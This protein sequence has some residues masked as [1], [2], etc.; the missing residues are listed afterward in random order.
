MIE[1]LVPAVNNKLTSLDVVKAELRIVTTEHDLMLN[2]MIDQASAI[3]TSFCGRP[4]AVETYQET[5]VGEDSVHLILGH[6]PI[7]SVTSVAPVIDFEVWKEAGM[8]YRVNGW[9]Q[10]QIFTIEYVA[11][12]TTIP[13]DIERACIDLTK[14]AFLA[15][16]RD[17][18]ITTE[19]IG[20]YGV[21]Y[22]PPGLERLLS[23]RRAI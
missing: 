21:S 17:P 20:D 23:W 19:R 8:L 16:R 15:R 4:F 12:Y 2:D 1:T 5:V 10:G 7:V 9:R 3:I 13:H 14:S 22:T 11:G 6:R 18:S